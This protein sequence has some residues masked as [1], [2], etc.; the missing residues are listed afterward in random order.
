MVIHEPDPI[1]TVARLA[2]QQE[3]PVRRALSKARSARVRAGRWTAA[4]V[5]GAAGRVSGETFI[6]LDYPPAAQDEP[7]YGWGRPPHARIAGILAQRDEVYRREL[8]VIA[9]YRDDLL[10]IPRFRGRASEP[11]WM[12]TPVWMLGLD[13]AS[14]YAF[15]RSR[16]PRRYLEIGSGASTR[17]VA[18]AKADG[19]LSTNIT[20]IDPYPRSEIDELCDSVLRQPLETVDRKLFSSLEP[21][22]MVFF[23][24]SHRAFMNSDVTV[25]FLD[26][27]PE[28]PPGVL[29][30]IHD[31]LLPWD[32]P[33]E[34]AGRFYSEQYL[35]AAG[36][37]AGDPQIQPVLPCHYIATTPALASTLDPLWDSPHFEGVD[38]R[39]FA[40]WFLTKE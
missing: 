15:M 16:R 10:R 39:G 29:V 14:L 40:F 6:A 38:R 28:L 2:A 33:P 7:Q 24:G 17:F 18:R 9:E 13:G 37:L 12:E 34:W 26:V 19:N 21:G 35:L 25:F 3:P 27:L 8:S 36:L 22:D 31:I 23:D 30:G 11:A 32:Y 4:R 1:G 5:A 20:S